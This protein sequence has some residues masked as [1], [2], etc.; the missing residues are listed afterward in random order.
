MPK[1]KKHYQCRGTLSYMAP[2]VLDQSICC[3]NGYNPE[4]TDLF[5]LGVIL[6][7][8]YMGKPPFRQADARKDDLFKM[9]CEF[10]YTQFWELWDTQWA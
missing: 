4:E 1:T 5:S 7:S 8:M 9:L 6:F 3:K 10:K 2:E